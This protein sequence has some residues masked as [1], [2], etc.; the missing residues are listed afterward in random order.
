MLL[1]VLRDLFGNTV[2]FSASQMTSKSLKRLG[3]VFGGMWVAHFFYGYDDR[4]LFSGVITPNDGNIGKKTGCSYIDNETGERVIPPDLERRQ[5]RRFIDAV[6]HL[7]DGPIVKY[8][9]EMRNPFEEPEE[10]FLLDG[11]GKERL[12][13][14]RELR[15]KDQELKK[16]EAEQLKN[17]KKS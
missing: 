7:P 17:A 2:T 16:Q 8:I 12:R 13:M 10:L 15:K 14:E 11:P 4:E 9:V 1:I 3:Q 6:T 5:F